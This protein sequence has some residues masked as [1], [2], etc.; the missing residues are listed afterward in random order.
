VE[1]HRLMKWFVRSAL[2]DGTLRI[3]SSANGRV[4]VVIAGLLL[5]IVADVHGGLIGQLATS[6]AIWFLALKLMRASPPDWRLALWACL[7]WATAGE[8]VLSLVWG[9]YAYRLGNIPFFVPPGHVLI[10]YV[11]MVLAPRVPRLLDTVVLVFALGYA[12]FAWIS[13]ADTLSIP[14]TLV[15]FLCMIR[16]KDRQLYALMFVLALSVELYGTWLGSWAWHGDVPWT[17]L[18]AANPPIAAG[19]FYCILDALV[20]LTV[21]RF[22]KK[23]PAR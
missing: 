9:L 23:L 20:G 17:S 1:S 4:A 12:A 7:V 15:F 10:L 6:V 22:A 13:A 11:G 8:M 3:G 21:R 16:R 2:L 14:L 19:A 18:T 5:G